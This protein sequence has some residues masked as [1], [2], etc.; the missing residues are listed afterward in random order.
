M[1]GKI[2]SLNYR[3]YK[4]LVRILAVGLKKILE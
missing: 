3:I 2:I 4:V 1:E